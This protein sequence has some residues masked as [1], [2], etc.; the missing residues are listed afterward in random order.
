MAFFSATTSLYNPKLV[1]TKIGQLVLKLE[2]LLRCIPFIFVTLLYHGNP[3]NKLL[4]P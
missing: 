1:M 4:Y 2:N 3:R